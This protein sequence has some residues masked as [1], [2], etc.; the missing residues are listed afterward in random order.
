MG[1]LSGVRVVELQ[2]IGPGPFCGMMLADMGAEVIRVDRSANAG[3]SRGIDVLARGRRSIAVDL[4]NPEGVETVLELIDSADAL[5]EGFRPGVMERLGLGPDVCLSRNPKLVYGRMTGWGQDGPY[6]SAAG[7]DINYIALGGAL[8]SIGRAGEAPVPPL[9]L[10]GDFGGG[11]MLLAFGIA[12]GIVSAR[13]T[14]QGQVVDAAMVDGTATL[15]S[16]FFSMKAMGIWGERGTNMLD[17]GA[18]FYDVYECADGEYVSI[19]SIEP[20]FYAQLMELSG[21]GQMDLPAQM[22]RGDWPDMKHKFAEV[23]RTKT[24]D[25]WCEIMEHTDVCFAP[26]LSLDEATAHPHNVE[27]QTFIEVDGVVQ[28]APSPRFS[29]TT[30]E[31]KGPAAV[32]GADTDAVLAE[33]GKSDDQIAALRQSGAVA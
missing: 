22:S 11:G 27:R 12:C 24:R 5:I 14:G 7:H 19:G 9:N 29:V 15:M 25:E 10:V 33:L 2:G 13:S 6:A 23:F 3:V 1:P 26:V 16:M 31:V 8:G 30:P 28:A 4:K 18:P 20:Q 17:T 32:P 21:L